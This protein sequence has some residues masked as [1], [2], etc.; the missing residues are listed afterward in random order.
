MSRSLLFLR[1]S[2]NEQRAPWD[3]NIT[4]V[5]NVD[6]SRIFKSMINERGDAEVDIR[7]GIGL[8]HTRC[9]TDQTVLLDSPKLSVN[10]WTQEQ[11]N[12]P[13]QGKF[14]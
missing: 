10:T 7:E 14:G 13:S 11:K 5:L 12:K 8:R 6:E 9:L 2:L 1:S 3:E 4:I